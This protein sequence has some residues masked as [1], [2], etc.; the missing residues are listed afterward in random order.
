MTNNLNLNLESHTLGD[1]SSK[2]I[3]IINFRNLCHSLY[4]IK[5]ELVIYLTLLI[6]VTL[7]QSNLL[8][9]EVLDLEMRSL[10]SHDSLP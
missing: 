5:F 3:A 2:L 1:L 10:L 8:A 7:R 6:I 9:I 4:M